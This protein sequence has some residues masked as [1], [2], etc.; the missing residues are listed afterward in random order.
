MSIVKRL[1]IGAAA[2]VIL[3]ATLSVTLFNKQSP[4]MSMTALMREGRLEMRQHNYRQ[5][6]DTYRLAIAVDKRSVEAYLELAKACILDGQL[7]DAEYF[8]RLGME[9]TN[10]TKIRDA[11]NDLLK[12]TN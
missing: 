5:A 6:V 3:L 2:L 11:Y 9:E 12:P 8:L 4:H 10:S 7:D 1:F